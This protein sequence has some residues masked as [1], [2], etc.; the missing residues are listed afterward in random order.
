MLDFSEISVPDTGKS[1]PSRWQ[2]AL[3]TSQYAVR[4]DRRWDWFYLISGAGGIEAAH[5]RCRITAGSPALFKLL[6]LR[7]PGAW[8]HPKSVNLLPDIVAVALGQFELRL[9]Q[10]P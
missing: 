2:A 9:G 5:K 3:G 1:R 6:R 10:L 7:L 4:A 8:D